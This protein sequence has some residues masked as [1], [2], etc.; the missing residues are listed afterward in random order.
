MPSTH[1]SS[2][3][4]RLTNIPTQTHKTHA[5]NACSHLTRAI[6]P[7]LDLSRF[8]CAGSPKEIHH[9]AS[10]QQR[11]KSPNLSIRGDG[12]LPAPY[13]NPQ[14]GQIAARGHT[15][16]GRYT[17]STAG[18]CSY[19]VVASTFPSSLS[20]KPRCREMV[21]ARRARDHSSYLPPVN[22][23]LLS[24]NRSFKYS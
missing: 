9:C 10:A 14:A 13:Y 17:S 11:P 16:L 2:N 12:L 19:F 6:C 23:Q 8:V 21:G 15:S 18:A 22:A 7:A 1:P 20:Q 24:S 3:S 4:P 5:H